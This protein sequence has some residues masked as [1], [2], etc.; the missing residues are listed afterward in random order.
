MKRILLAITAVV[1]ITGIVGGSTVWANV[2]NNIAPDQVFINTSVKSGTPST[3][4]CPSG[5]RHLARKNN[6]DLWSVYFRVI[7]GATQI[8]ASYS[9]DGGENWIEEQIS[10]GAGSQRNTSIAVDS[11][12]NIHVVWQ[13]KGWGSNPSYYNIQYRKRTTSWQ[14]QE[15]VT[16]KSSDQVNPGIAIDAEDNVHVVWQGKGWGSNPG[17]FNIRYRKRIDSWQLQEAITDKDQ[18]QRSPSIAVDGIGNVHVVWSGIGWG[19]NPTIDNIQYRKRTSSWQA[20]EHVSD[21]TDFQWGPCVAVDTNNNVHVAWYGDGWAP[22]VG[23]H[24]IRYRQRTTSSW[25]VHEALTEINMDQNS[26]SIALDKDG[27]V[28][29]AWFGKGWGT[30]PYKYNIQLRKRTN[31]WQVQEN[32]TDRNYDQR[33]ASLIWAMHPIATN[34]PASGYALIWAGRDDSG[35]ELEFRNSADLSWDGSVVPPSTCTLTIGTIGDGTTDPAPNVWEYSDGSQVTISAIPAS[36]WV[37]DY[38]S[39]D[40]SGTDNPITIT[41][42]S[43]KSVAAHFMLSTSPNGTELLIIRLDNVDLPLLS[44]GTVVTIS[45]GSICE[46]GVIIAVADIPE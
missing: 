45:C 31:S 25:Q 8:F 19:A 1:L 23:R 37:F 32:L 33:W 13:G 7:D 22:Y 38:W 42:D 35:Y 46:T 6:G 28:Y 24:Q 44:E 41:M 26:P 20:Q 40:A 14:T 2:G 18:N 11:K 43:N 27:N 34:I 10:F 36:G 29:V 5:V 21:R 9:T 12:D 15:A 16:D 39:G 17:F 4:T 30:Y 3:A